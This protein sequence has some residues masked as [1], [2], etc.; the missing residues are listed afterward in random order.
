MKLLI[1]GLF[2]FTGAAFAANLAPA[3]YHSGTLVSFPL[4][5]SGSSCTGSA[6]QICSDDY[7]AEYMVKSE[8]ILYALTPAGATSGSFAERVMLAWSRALSRNDSLYH[9]QPGTPLLL[10]DD[11]RHLFV[12]VGS[13][14]SKYI[15]IE[16]R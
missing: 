2:A 14:E 9:Q 16:A 6:E 13:R 7:Q 15:A 10:R 1:A 11:G 3:S 8:G 12:K 4:Q 5:A